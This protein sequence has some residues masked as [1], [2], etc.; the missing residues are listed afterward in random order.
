MRFEATR[1]TGSNRVLRGGNWN[2]NAQNARSANR[3]NNTPANRNNNNGFRLASPGA[4]RCSTARSD[5]LPH[6]V[7]RSTSPLTTSR[8]LRPAQPGRR[9]C[10]LP[11]M[12]ASAALREGRHCN[13]VPIITRL[14]QQ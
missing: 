12:R 8:R 11:A 1:R 7:P 10:P 3:N 2:N 9:V 5:A 4:L 14:S 6:G 13:L